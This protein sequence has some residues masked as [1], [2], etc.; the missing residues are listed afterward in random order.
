MFEDITSDGS[1]HWNPSS[2]IPP[3]S[4]EVLAD[5]LNVDAIQDLDNED[6][7]VQPSP[8]DVGATFSAVKRLA[9]FVHGGTRNP[10]VH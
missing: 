1:D 8:G 9:K 6:I 4:S 2:G 7:E 3:S 5:A 10:R